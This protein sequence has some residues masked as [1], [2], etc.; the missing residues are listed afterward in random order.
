MQSIFRP[1]RLTLFAALGGLVLI[2]AACSS[3]GGAASTAGP[4][5]S[6][7]TGQTFVVATASGAVGDYLTGAGGMTL[8]TFSPDSMDTSTCTGSCA[9]TWPPLT[10]AAGVTPTGAS[11]VTGT[12]STFTR[13]DG[14]LQ[15]AHDGAPLYYYA[16]DAKAG[17]TNGQ[18][19]GGKW[20]VASPTG[21]AASPSGGGQ[22]G[23]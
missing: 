20:Y 19:V 5:A 21:A 6:A 14:S 3:A 11:G 22:P 15:V 23:Y 9:T 18:G 1:A 12:L 7:G 17:D 10:V 4:S 2:V 13:P 16:G 8:Y